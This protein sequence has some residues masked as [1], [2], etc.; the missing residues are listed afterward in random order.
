MN[1]P[2]RWLRK[3]RYSL[4]IYKVLV[5]DDS[6]LY[7]SSIKL[8]LSRV[9]WLNV[10]ETARNGFEAFEFIKDHPVDLVILDMEMPQW[11][12]LKFL[13]ELQSLSIRPQVIVFSSYSRNGAEQTMEALNAGANDFATKPESENGRAVTSKILDALLP[14]IKNLLGQDSEEK[15]ISPSASFNIGRYEL[16]V[17]GAST[18][19]PKA[20][21]EF[22]KLAAS[23]INTPIIIVQHMPALFTSSFAES[24]AK[25]TGKDCHEAQNGEVIKAGSIYIAPGDFH[26]RLKKEGKDVVA[27]ISQD[28]HI[29]FVRPAVDPLFVSAS[30]IYRNQLLAIVFSGM[31]SDGREGARFIKSNHGKVMIQD[32]KSSV[33]FGMP[34]GIFEDK[35]YDFIG[36]PGQIAECF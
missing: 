23:K 6:I 20:V 24:L 32:K 15:H 28:D 21:S 25:I 33:V 18:G 27:V 36:T 3:R 2:L 1:R 9:P 22:C 12:G 10:V 17:I 19:G 5:V 30:E 29:N 31:G 26:L 8:A 11:N 7:R 14:K 4:K 35:N 13:Q 16:V 34:G